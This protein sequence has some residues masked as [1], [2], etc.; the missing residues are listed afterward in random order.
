MSELNLNSKLFIRG[1]DIKRGYCLRS[2]VF[3]NE[4]LDSGSYIMLRTAFENVLFNS[5][6]SRKIVDK[7]I[8]CI[9]IEFLKIITNFT[10]E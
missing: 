9:A 4:P 10:I 6:F 7:Q 5:I 1:R 8:G 2:H 3:D